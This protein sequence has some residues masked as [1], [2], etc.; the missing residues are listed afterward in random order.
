MRQCNLMS[1]SGFT[2]SKVTRAQTLL[3]AH[4]VN[5]LI[6][7]TNRGLCRGVL[8]VPGEEKEAGCVFIGTC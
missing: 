2:A 4:T 3:I 6:H 1:V 5:A 7:C 8:D